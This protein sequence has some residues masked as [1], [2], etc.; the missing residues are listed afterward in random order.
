MEPIRLLRGQRRIAKLQFLLE[1]A[2][3]RNVGE[4]LDGRR[5][6]GMIVPFLKSV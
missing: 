4:E 1:R 3:R 2:E 5:I 6:G